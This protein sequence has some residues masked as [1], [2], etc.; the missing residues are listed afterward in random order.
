ML[1]GIF[2][3]LAVT[4]NISFVWPQTVR[5]LRTRDLSGISPGTWAISVVLFAGWAAYAVGIQYWSLAFANLSCLLAALIIMIVGTRRG[6]PRRWLG[7]C[8]VGAACGVLTAIL[9]PLVLVAAMALSGVALRIPQT[10]RLMRSPNVSGVSSTTWILSGA[11]AA[12]WLVISIHEEA[13]GVVV[14]NM[15]ALAATLVLLT[16]LFWRQRKPASSSE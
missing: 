1:I 16:V 9:A 13:W 4:A 7:L 2:T 14:A 8:I 3:V 5:L 10:L 6:W 11:T 15:S 12:C